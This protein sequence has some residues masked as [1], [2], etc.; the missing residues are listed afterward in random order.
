MAKPSDLSLKE[1]LWYHR[2]RF[3]RV[4]PLPWQPLEPPVEESRVAIVTSA[5]LHV[6]GDDPFQKV[7]G[8]DYSYRVIPADATVGSLELSHPSDAWDT[9]GVERDRNLALPLDRL[10]EMAGDGAIGT[11]AP[12]HIS[13][14]GSITAPMRL[15]K[16]S[17]P[18]AGKLLADDGVD[19]VILTPV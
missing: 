10:A 7:K 11:V 15:Q 9:S 18:E 19:V 2:Y 17:A 3:R 5:G 12:R 6:P 8:G 4:D 16:Q 13:F 1:R 14:Q